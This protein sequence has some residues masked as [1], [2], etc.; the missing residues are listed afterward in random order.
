MCSH[1]TYYKTV[2]LKNTWLQ[3][4]IIWRFVVREGNKSFKCIELAEKNAF[5]Y[6]GMGLRIQYC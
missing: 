6:L 2:N 4:N 5:L 3:Y 1:E